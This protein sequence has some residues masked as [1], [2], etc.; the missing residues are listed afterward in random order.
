MISY[1]T[2]L[3]RI[4]SVSQDSKVQTQKPKVG[5]MYSYIYNPK[6]KD[7]LPYYDMVPLV[8]PV[9]YTN[10]GFYGLNFHYLS[11]Q[12]R[13]KLLNM[14]LPFSKK[15]MDVKKI[16]ISYGQLST[17]A[18]GMWSPCCKRYLWTH[19]VTKVINI[20]VKDWFEVIKLPVISF[21][22]AS[23]SEVYRLTKRKMMS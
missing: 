16:Q 8:I 3:N 14:I 19:I 4:K 7:K 17:L 5:K 22:N 9:S 15:N 6:T 1:K 23:S 11:L 18:S 13:N 2:I 20:P 21:K 10:N 12:E